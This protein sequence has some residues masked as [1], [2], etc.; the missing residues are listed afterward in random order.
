MAR[1][2]G[3]QYDGQPDWWITWTFDAVANVFTTTGAGDAQVTRANPGDYIVEIGAGGIDSKHRVV[4]V[5]W[6]LDPRAII[7]GGYFWVVHDVDDTH[8]EIQFFDKTGA[9]FD[10][11]R[12]AVAID[13]LIGL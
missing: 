1:A 2:R 10:P 8:K 6:E 11:G 7:V 12:V 13:R 9:A 5:D 4:R 3:D